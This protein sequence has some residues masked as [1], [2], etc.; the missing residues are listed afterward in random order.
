MERPH[1]VHVH[2]TFAQI[3]PSIFGACREVGVPVVHT[4]HNFRLLC[5]AATFFREGKIC[6]KC[7]E[8]SL[9]QSIRHACYR[10]SYGATA[11]VALMLAMHRKARTWLDGV[12][13]YIALTQFAR[14]KFVEG[15]LPEAR[16]SV[17]PNFVSPDPGEKKRK[18]EGAVF[19]GRLSPEKGV[20]NLLRAW[21][22]LRVP[23]PLRILGDG[24]MREELMQMAYDLKLMQVRFL[25]HVDHVITQS[26]I[27]DA[28]FLI[29]PSECYENFPLTIIEALSC[30][31]PVI[32]SRL[33]AMQEIVTHEGTGLHFT[34]GNPEELA[35]RVAWAWDHPSQVKDMGK[36]A[37]QEYEQKY[38][39]ERN[40]DS[41]MSIYHHAIAAPT[42]PYDIFSLSSGFFQG[43]RR[44][45]GC[46]ADS[47]GDF[48]NDPLDRRTARG[49]LHCRNG[50]AR[51]HGSPT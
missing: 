38:T 18:G 9:W 50:N 35:D 29:L 8:S 37:R 6:E 34:P 41:L 15:G 33:G 10:Q 20:K 32:C 43:I 24:P 4:L 49:K 47:R 13:T 48:P 21:G 45:C 30:G 7:Q 22:R 46:R 23:I 40:Y 16:I 25:G 42:L 27:K 17:K 11:T 12:T 28:M 39:A 19:V 36:A 31:T 1:I 51:S 14:R 5:P 44:P 3:S 26:A 2:N